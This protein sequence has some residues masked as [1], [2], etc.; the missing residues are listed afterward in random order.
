MKN[1]SNFC[2]NKKVHI[3][4]KATEANILEIKPWDVDHTFMLLHHMELRKLFLYLVLM[5]QTNAINTT[6]RWGQMFF[7]D[8]DRCSLLIYSFFTQPCELEALYQK[9]HMK[10]GGGLYEKWKR[11]GSFYRQGVYILIEKLNIS[12]SKLN[13]SI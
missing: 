1:L 6:P 5:I 2:L 11:L 9:D 8:G 13:F 7:Q 10:N 3:F 4:M 12:E